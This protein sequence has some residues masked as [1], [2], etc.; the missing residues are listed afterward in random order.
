MS[1]ARMRAR[2]RRARADPADIGPALAEL[3]R[4]VGPSGAW[5]SLTPAERD[6]LGI[7]LGLA[8]GWPAVWVEADGRP[9]QRLVRGQCPR[10]GT[11][12]VTRL[13]SVLRRGAVRRHTC[14]GG[15]A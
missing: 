7:G 5:V 9:S 8:A 13:R 3:V 12:M 15:G 6:E 10:C 1:D 14:P 2:F 4:V 11:R